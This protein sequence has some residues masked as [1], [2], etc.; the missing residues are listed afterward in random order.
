MRIKISKEIPKNIRYV[1]QKDNINCGPLSIL[2]MLKWCGYNATR[3]YLK[4]LKTYCKTTKYGTE[5]KNISQT[6][7]RYKNIKFKK[8]NKVDTKILN[9]YLNNGYAA[10]ILI[11]KWIDSPKR[12]YFVITEK[13]EKYNYVFYKAINWST[14]GKIIWL[15]KEKL[16]KAFKRSLIME[17]D[18]KI[19]FVKRKD[20]EPRNNL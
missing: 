9:H 1:I 11:S 14:D 12:H 13:K 8:I 16:I 3:K 10:I 20:N 18:P 17:K 15:T 6:L 5:N 4:D 19:W 2:N 7:K